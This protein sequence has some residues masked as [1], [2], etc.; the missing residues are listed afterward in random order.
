MKQ[1]Y[2]LLQK[3]KQRDFVELCAP[4]PLAKSFWNRARELFRCFAQSDGQAKFM[5][6]F[7]RGG[8]K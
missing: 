1:A 6:N 8:D 7:T 2:R 5:S 4:N 3:M